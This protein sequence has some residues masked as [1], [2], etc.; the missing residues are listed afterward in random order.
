MRVTLCM[1]EI[2][3]IG[4]ELALTFRPLLKCATVFSMHEEV[5]PICSM[6][7]EG[8]GRDNSGYPVMAGDVTM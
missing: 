5:L 6:T 4:L 7:S 1:T 2:F 3:N 8:D